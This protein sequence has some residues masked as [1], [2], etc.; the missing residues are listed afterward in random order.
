MSYLNLAALYLDRSTGGEQRGAFIKLMASFFPDW[1]ANFPYVRSVSIIS[2]VT[3]GHLFDISIPEILEM[4][5]DRNW[6]RTRPPLPEVAA[7][8]HYSNTIQYVENICYRM[9]DRRA[10]LDFDYS[11]RQAN[12]RKVNVGAQQYRDKLMLIQFK[13]GAG[14]FSQAQLKLIDEQHLPLPDLNAI[15]LAISGLVCP[16][17]GDD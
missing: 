2:R 5:L 14:W 16:G 13:D 17:G 12:Y 6:G 3:D 15:R 1:T 10:G 7:P 9:R 4:R 8:D 11:H